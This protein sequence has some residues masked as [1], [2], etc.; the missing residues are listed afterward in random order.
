MYEEKDDNN[1][2][3]GLI[4]TTEPGNTGDDGI[5]VNDIIRT[6]HNDGTWDAISLASD[7][8]KTKE[9]TLFGT[10]AMVDSTDTDQKK[11][12]LSYPKDQRYGQ[13]YAASGDATATATTVGGSAGG[14]TVTEI[15]NVVVA[16]SALSVANV[17][18]LVVIGGSCVNTVAASLLGASAPLCGK[19]FTD[20]TGVGE[21]LALAQVFDRGNG[22][23]ALLVAGYNAPDTLSLADYLTKNPVDT[24]VGK[25]YIWTTATKTLEA[26]AAPTET[27]ATATV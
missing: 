22:V 8:K 27:T 4:V 26:K 16:D 17:K 5:G 10:V 21:G 3:E 9:A 6:W 24:S 23:T 20:K 15:G 25:R 2:Y 11:G 1:R 13:I 19:E 18:N 7:S 12:I 14:V